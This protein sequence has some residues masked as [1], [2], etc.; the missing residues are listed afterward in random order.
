MRPIKFRGKL[1]IQYIFKAFWVLV[2]SLVA[3]YLHEK[4]IMSFDVTTLI[5]VLMIKTE[6]DFG[7]KQ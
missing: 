7:A 1:I 2:W 6:Q 4:E 3:V 5:F